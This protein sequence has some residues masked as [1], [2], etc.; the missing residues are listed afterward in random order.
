MEVVV[1]PA[2]RIAALEIE[3]DRLKER[4]DQL[5]AQLQGRVDAWLGIQMRMP[6]TVAEVYV[7][8]LL[9]EARQHG[10]AYATVCRTLAALTAGAAEDAEPAEDPGEAAQRKRAE[11]LRLVQGGA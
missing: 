11:R 5:D 7:D 8:K 2:E 3:A 10:L 6:E 4:L 9:A 1:T